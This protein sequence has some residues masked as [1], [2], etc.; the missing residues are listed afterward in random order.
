MAS[1][2]YLSKSKLMSGQQ[3]AKRLWLE[4]N[5]PDELEHSASTERSFAIGHAVGD[6]AQSLYPAGILIESALS[7]LGFGIQMPIPSWG[8]LVNESKNAAHWWIHVFPGVLIFVTVL[9]YNL[10][11]DG[12]RDAMDPKLKS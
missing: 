5:E 6:A 1:T 2:W 11:G 12:V 9:C 4:V 3:C 8:S 10:V 7:F